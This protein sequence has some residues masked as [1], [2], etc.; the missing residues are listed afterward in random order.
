MS[1][2]NLSAREIQRQWHLMDAKNQTLGRLATDIAKL[3][4]GKNKANYV[5]YL[6][7]GDNVVVV[8]AAKV[9]VSG[10]KE[11]QKKYY[12]HSGYPG[13]LKTET[14]AEVRAEKPE[15][16]VIHAVKGMIP[17]TKLGR[18]MIK[19]LHVFAETTHPFKKQVK[20]ENKEEVK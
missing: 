14:L 13:G 17:H 16:L 20:T 3:L 8:N 10:K 19:K 5:P 6:D 11:T 4:M 9:K 18:Q 1:T 15:Q 7:L 2:N 12:R